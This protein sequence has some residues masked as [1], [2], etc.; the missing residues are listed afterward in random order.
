MDELLM[1]RYALAK[2]RV[3]E[4]KEEKAVQMP[5]LDFFQ[6]TAAFLE[7]NVE[8]MDGV[9]FLGEAREPRKLADAADLSIDEWKELN[10]DLY[11]DILPEN[12]KNSYGNPVYACEK[13]GEYGKDFS[14]LY[15]EL[16]GIVVYAFEKRLWDITVLLELFLEVYGAFAQ[17]E[18]PTEEELRGILNSYAN[19]YC[20]DMIEYRTRE[21]VDPEL[22]FAAKL[23]MNSDFSD[24]RYLYL[25]GECI[26]ENELGV[27]A[28]LNGLSQEEID[29]CA[30][31]YTEGYRLGF[32][33]GHKDLSKK[34]TVNI[35]YNLGFERMDKSRQF[36]SLRRW[37]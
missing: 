1:E 2:E 21:C 6:K 27:A 5:Y 14:F 20:Q 28:F 17:E 12:Y 35:R 11:A 32:V 7:K 24:L 25:F 23:F 9:V 19:D 22:D 30:R 8:I 15:A 33:N 10:R 29:S 3:C 16:R 37:G 18:I 34:K 13:L 36:F 26:T 31:T 4:I